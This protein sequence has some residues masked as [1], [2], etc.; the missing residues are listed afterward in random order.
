MRRHI[1]PQLFSVLLTFIL[2]KGVGIC[3]QT[4]EPGPSKRASAPIQVTQ[5]EEV[6][7]NLKLV[8]IGEIALNNIEAEFVSPPAWI[9]RTAERTLV[10]IPAKSTEVTRPTTR[11]PFTFTVDKNAPLDISEPMVLKIFST[12]PTGESQQTMQSNRFWTKAI[13]LV[14]AP[15]PLPSSFALLQ[16]YPNPFNPETWIPY[17]LAKS[18]HVTI[19]IYN[20]SGRLVRHL[21][22][23]FQD[24]GFYVK[25]ASAAY[26]DGRND[27]GERVASGLYFYHLQADDAYAIRR[28]LILK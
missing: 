12:T 6:T 23:G 14:V 24:A 17:Q 5:G 19:D 26:W 25:R 28:M 7:L 2:F 18:A 21:D 15:R 16:N 8:N 9:H 1:V 3:A 13:Q 11:L 20:V 4:A 22:V 10:D 27:V